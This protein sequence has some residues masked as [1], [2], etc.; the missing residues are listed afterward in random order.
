[1]P[2]RIRRPA[3]AL[4][5]VRSVRRRPARAETADVDTS[6]KEWK[7]LGIGDVKSLIKGH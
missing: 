3:A 2:P 5:K 7:D 1:M 6:Y 4:A